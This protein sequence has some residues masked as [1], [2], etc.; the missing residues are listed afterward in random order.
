MIHEFRLETLTASHNLNDVHDAVL[1]F[2]SRFESSKQKS[3]VSTK[4]LRIGSAHH[5]DELGRQ[6]ERRLLEACKMKRFKL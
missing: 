4:Q 5:I 3:L 6:F 1:L 2:A